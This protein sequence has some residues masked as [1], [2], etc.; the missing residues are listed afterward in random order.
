MQD[1]PVRLIGVYN[2]DGGFLGE[3]KY[4]FSQMVG[5]GKCELCDITHS[6]IRRKAS[7]DA[8]RVRL[9]QEYGIEVELVHLNERTE[10]Q[11][12]AS[13]GNVPCVLAEFPDGKYLMFLDRVDLKAVQGDV[14]AFEKLVRARLG[15]FF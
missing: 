7:F 2:A 11:E 8:F 13:S 14:G 1:K 12:G 6:P 10:G 5:I 4:F 9:N 3:L 15:L